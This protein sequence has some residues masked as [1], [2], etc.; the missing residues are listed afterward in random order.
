MM[1]LQG[2]ITDFCMQRHISDIGRNTIHQRT[3][4][5]NMTFLSLKRRE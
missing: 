3:R 4:K 1:N 2:T 5:L